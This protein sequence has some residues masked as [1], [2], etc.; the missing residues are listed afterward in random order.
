MKKYACFIDWPKRWTVQTKLD[1]SNADPKEILNR[2]AR[3][4]LYQ[5]LVHAAEY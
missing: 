4:K 3:T 2:L 5:Q 1:R